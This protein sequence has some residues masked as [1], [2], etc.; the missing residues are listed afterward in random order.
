MIV[1]PQ[2]RAALKQITNSSLP[3]LA[4]LSLNEVTR[5]TEVEAVGQVGV[6]I[7]QEAAVTAP[8]A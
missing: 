3:T 7:I 2:I 6:D 8:T 4:V 1:S 5:D